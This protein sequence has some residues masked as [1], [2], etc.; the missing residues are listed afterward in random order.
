LIERK[1]DSFRIQVSDKD[2]TE[3]HDLKADGFRQHIQ[4]F[5]IQM[6]EI[7]TID[8]ALQPRADQ[9][10]YDLTRALSAVVSIRCEV[11][12]NAF[13]AP[14]LG[15][16][17][18]GH[19][20]LI[21]DSGLVLTIGYLTIEAQK[22]W[23]I[24]A[25][26][27]AVAGHVVAYDQETGFGLVQALG[28]LNVPALT[29]GSSTGLQIG[30]DVI[31]AGHG[32]VTNAVSARV[33][34]KQE[35][36]GYWEYLLNEAIFTTPPHPF[37]GGAALISEQGELVGIGSLFIQH[38]R[39]DQ[40]PFDG[41][42]IVPIDILKPILDDLLTYG[43]VNK[44]PRPWLGT[45]IAESDERLYVA[46]V[47]PDGPSATSGLE[48]GDAL[49]AINGHPIEELPTFFRQL[50]GL[51]DAG[52]TITLSIL[53]EDQHFDVQIK[54]ADRNDYLLRPDIH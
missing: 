17:R 33:A 15:T 29:L 31:L 23:L 1:I 45:M 36:A 16:E 5:R 54:T 37:W 30:D 53:R 13:T 43:R 20:V 21:R 6:E 40:S 41:N 10:S 38:A 49:T 48:P 14:S 52:I 44:P 9:V 12:D 32:G 2:H 51:G 26:G 46:G 35:F 18:N 24:D 34:A 4:E 7:P 50:W 8:P 47:I 39:E 11:P 42:M 28:K 27:Q 19:G 25:T 22:L 3:W